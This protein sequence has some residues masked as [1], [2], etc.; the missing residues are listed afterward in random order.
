M[1]AGVFNSQSNYIFSAGRFVE[2]NSRFDQR[3]RIKAPTHK[4]PSFA[5]A[6]LSSSVEFKK[7]APQ[8]R[9]LRARRERVLR[10]ITPPRF[11][12]RKCFTSTPSDHRRNHKIANSL[13]NIRNKYVQRVICAGKCPLQKKKAILSWTRSCGNQQNKQENAPYDFEGAAFASHALRQPAREL[14]AQQDL[15]RSNLP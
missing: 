2:I 3:W 8:R 10:L 12:T 7:K 15:A 13:A 4:K 9:P 14:S 5:K 1:L 6:S 11:F